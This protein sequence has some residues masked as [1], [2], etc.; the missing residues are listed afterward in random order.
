MEEGEQMSEQVEASAGVR[1]VM[2]ARVRETAADIMRTYENL[3][4]ASTTEAAE[5]LKGQVDAVASLRKDKE[6]GQ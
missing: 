4:G 6:A 1:K 3:T 2:G 5:W